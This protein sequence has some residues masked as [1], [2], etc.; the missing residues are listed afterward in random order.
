MKKRKLVWLLCLVALFVL[1]ACGEKSKEDVEKD[2]ANKAEEMK[3]YK[4]TAQMTLQAGEEK[5]AYNVEIWN[6]ENNFYRVELS[7][8]KKDQSQMIL[9]NDSGVYVLTP[10]L[11][12]SFKFQS[13]WPNN[14][15]QAYLFEALV[16]DIQSDQEATFKETDNHY[17]FET[18]TR[19]PNSHMLPLQE[20]TFQ[21]KDL[22]P[23]SVKVMDPDRKPVLTVNF[24]KVDFDAKFEDSSFDVK[25][26]MTGAQL[27]MPVVAQSKDEEFTVLYPDAKSMGSELLEENEMVTAEG[28]RI[29][30]TYGGNKA[31][32]VIQEKASALPTA[33]V[34]TASMSGEVANLGFAFGE[35]TEQ[36][37]SW[38]Y[39]GVDYMVASKDLSK[40]EMIEVAQSMQAA[41]EK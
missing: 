11:N 22:S 14:S 10:S 2:L 27:E 33:S 8:A 37:L 5:Q 3:G 16:K 31:F 41:M 19:Y 13:E 15:S 17:V 28:K 25:K 36:S 21:K 1:A 30:L 6:K 29:V 20:I 18:K 26:N 32:T 12:K 9:K 4:A 34:E 39:K 40:E 38:N 7:T 24:K 35:I 23:V